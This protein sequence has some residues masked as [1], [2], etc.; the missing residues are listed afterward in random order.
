MDPIYESYK[1]AITPI[2]EAFKPLTKHSQHKW[3]YPSIDPTSYY[4]ELKTK[5]GDATVIYGSGESDEYNLV[6][7]DFSPTDKNRDSIYFVVYDP[8][9]PKGIATKIANELKKGNVFDVTR[10]YK[11]KPEDN[12][13]YSKAESA[14]L[15]KELKSK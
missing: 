14:A 1:E 13:A 12:G 2:A 7:V 6:L 11:L 15:E 5:G 9:D 8:K 10:K 4:T 3:D